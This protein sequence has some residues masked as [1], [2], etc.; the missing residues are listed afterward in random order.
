MHALIN[1][2]IITALIYIFAPIIFAIICC[3]CSLSCLKEARSLE[4]TPTSKIRSAAQGFVELT[5][6]SRAFPD[7]TLYAK[8]TQEPCAWYRYRIEKLVAEGKGYSWRIIEEGTS[9]DPFLLRDATGECIVLPEGAEIIPTTLIR[10]RG[11][12]PSPNPPSTSLLI[13]FFWNCFGSY[14]YTEYQITIDTRLYT[15]GMFYTWPSNHPQL[16]SHSAVTAY[17][18]K[19]P[20]REYNVLVKTGL[21]KD[22]HFILSAISQD[23]L[24]FRFKIKA[25]LFFLGFLFLVIVTVTSSYPLIKQVLANPTL[26]ARFTLFKNIF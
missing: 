23:R 3:Y 13:R 6:L 26:K 5:G 14:R 4:D 21:P 9:S 2:D 22:E 1:T 15:A 8:L 11:S 18:E 19:Q 12:S 16:S 7:D 10:W 17:L 20:T 24:V 25:L